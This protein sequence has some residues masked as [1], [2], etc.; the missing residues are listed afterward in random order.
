MVLIKLYVFD[1]KET[2]EL[3]TTVLPSGF[4]KLYPQD[5]FADQSFS[6]FLKKVFNYFRIIY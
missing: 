1:S 5:V 2:F 6:I 4:A 3:N